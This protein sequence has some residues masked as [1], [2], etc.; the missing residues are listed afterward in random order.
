MGTL[1]TVLVVV[2]VA[3]IGVALY[4]WK[5]PRRE[6]PERTPRAE[7]EPLEASTGWTREAGSEFAGLGESARCDLIFAVGAFDDERSNALLEHA[8]D[9]PAVAVAT[10]AAHALASS[11]RRQIVEQYLRANPGERAERIGEVLALLDPDPAL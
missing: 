7:R 6:T 3:A 8:L 5:A 10:A 9:D 11:G 4:S 1:A 2:L